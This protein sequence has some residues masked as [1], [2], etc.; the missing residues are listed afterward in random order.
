MGKFGEILSSK[1]GTN[2]AAMLE[3][4]N[5]S[6]IGKKVL[7]KISGEKKSDDIGKA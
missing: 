5:Q 7:N 2:L 3:A 1:G 6:E 4:L